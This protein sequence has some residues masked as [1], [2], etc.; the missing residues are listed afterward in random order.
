MKRPAALDLFLVAAGT[1]EPCDR[2]VLVVTLF[3]KHVEL[4]VVSFGV[5]ALCAAATDLIPWKLRELPMPVGRKERGRESEP[6]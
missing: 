2:D 6:R 1:S 4:K 5:S 3:S